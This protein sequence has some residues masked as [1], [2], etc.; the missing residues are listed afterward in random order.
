[1]RFF[2][3]LIFIAVFGLFHSVTAS[4]F[5]Q[6]EQQDHQSITINFTFPKPDISPVDK[7]SSTALITIPGLILNYREAEPLLPIYT[8]AVVVPPGQ[9]SWKII[10]SEKQ[11]LHNVYPII[12][13]SPDNQQTPSLTSPLPPVYPQSIVQLQEAGIFRDYRIMGLSVYPVQLTPQ[14]LLC[15]ESIKI[16]IFFRNLLTHSR[17]PSHQRNPD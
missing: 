4:T 16:K 11:S 5:Y 1:M 17:R 8:T 6:V 15:Y 10:H 2:I 9:I 3:F 7:N 12:Y 14:G 13:Y